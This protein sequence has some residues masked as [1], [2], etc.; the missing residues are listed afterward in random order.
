[1][2][3]LLAIAAF[4]VVS[5]Q[6]VAQEYSADTTLAED[7][8]MV[9]SVTVEDIKALVVAEGHTLTGVGTYGD[10]SV[11]AKT[12]DG[13]IFHVIGSACEDNAEEGCLGF[14][15]QV[16]YTADEDV[17]LEAV[18]TANLTYAAVTAWLDKDSNT[19]GVLRYVI[20][21]GGQTME[22]LKVNLTNALL[23]APLV[24]DIIWPEDDIWED[25]FWGDL[26]DE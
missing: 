16:H 7:T 2:R 14:M 26:D 6:A 15:I 8:R 12:E 10:V 22:N 9:R 3:A 23:L 24:R 5:F 18:N 13:L 1:M 19:L 11:R 17:T 25:D 21:D 4:A 20:L